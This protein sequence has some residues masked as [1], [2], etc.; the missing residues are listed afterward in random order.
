MSEAEKLDNIR[1]AALAFM[2][3]R[4]RKHGRA[5]LI[6]ALIEGAFLVSYCLLADFHNRL[7]VL[8]LISTVAVY[9]ILGAGLFALG[10]FI[11]QA[12]LRILKALEI[13]DERNAA[14]GKER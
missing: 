3:K 7:H 6:A 14:R 10:I 12:V 1:G 9:A 5:I 13:V 11:N 8:L 2:E 4:D